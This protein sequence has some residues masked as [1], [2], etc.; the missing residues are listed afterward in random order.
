MAGYISQVSAMVEKSKVPFFCKTITPADGNCFFH[1]IVDQVQRTDMVGTLS[2]DAMHFCQSHTDLRHG[3]VQFIRSNHAF[4]TTENFQLLKS[5]VMGQSSFSSFNHY[6]ENM[7]RNGTWADTLVIYAM[8]IFLGKDISLLDDSRPA[9]SPWETFLGRINSHGTPPA[10]TIAYFHNRHFQSI[11]PLQN[12]Q[13]SDSQSQSNQSKEPMT[14]SFCNKSFK[15]LNKH[16]SRST[17]CRTSLG[18]ESLEAFRSDIRKRQTERYRSMY[19]SQLKE[20][21]TE[22]KKQNAEVL[23]MKQSIYKKDNA[24][25][26]KTKHQEYNIKNAEDIKSKQQEYNKKNAETI[27]SKQQDYNK[28]NA[29]K[30]R[31]HQQVYNKINSETIK[32]KQAQ[33]NKEHTVE[34]QNKQAIYNKENSE[35]V[36]MRQRL[37]D[38]NIR[39][40]KRIAQKEYDDKNKA[41]KI[42]QQSIYNKVNK[43]LIAMKQA[44]RRLETF[45][46]IGEKQRYTK[47]KQSIREGINFTCVC[48]HRIFFRD[49]DTSKGTKEQLKNCLDELAPGLYERTVFVPDSVLRGS[50]KCHLCHTCNKYLFKNHTMPPL[51]YYNGLELDKIPDC[52]EL[53]ELESTLIAKNI[54]FLKMFQLPVS[55]W[56]A[57]KDT[58]VNVPVSDNDLERTLSSV[59]SLPRNPENAGLIA[60]QL[61]RKLSYK[62][63]VTESFVNPTKLLKALLFLKHHGHPGYKN[64]SIDKDYKFFLRLDKKSDEAS[65]DNEDCSSDDNVF[66]DPCRKDHQS[67][68]STLMIDDHPDMRVV[69]NKTNKT[70]HK[71][72]RIDSAM[73]CP[74]AP[75]EGKIPVNLLRDEN[76]DTN[77]FPQLFPTG[78]FGLHFRRER[79]LTAQQYLIQRHLNCDKRFSTYPPFL[80]SS[81]YYVER[82]QLEQQINV[83]VLKGSLKDGK[84]LTVEDGFSVFDNIPGT[85]RYWQ[86]KRYET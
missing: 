82:Q 24:E 76:W 3:I 28:K 84:F 8:S 73:S 4:Q 7:D 85:P 9:S 61:K 75:G 67:E 70:M 45:D 51:C 50:P 33:Y 35:H 26:I 21:H 12:V 55:R 34:I 46:N 81:V 59:S 18:W 37:Y 16:L 5:V 38:E 36:A 39:T 72:Q 29:E 74:I 42:E 13:N 69:L 15:E 1:A 44:F 30:I 40:Q 58:V 6:L 41:R 63:T 22:Y 25:V 23:R 49:Q 11:H 66:D 14:C 43:E 19:K 60:V 80:F 71:K 65:D 79:K 47:F 53:N 78:R 32:S 20:K 77:A 57:I 52:L 27:K 31:I 68:G 48:C 64:V 62:N 17:K 86:Q 54:I 83:S 56:S 10:L 2:H